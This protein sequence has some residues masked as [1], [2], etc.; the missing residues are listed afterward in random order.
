MMDLIFQ[1]IIKRP[2]S[3]GNGV[4][5]RFIVGRNWCPDAFIMESGGTEVVNLME[6]RTTCAATGGA[7][8]QRLN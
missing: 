3:A 8:G 1:Y 7:V 2:S 5:D 6:R 4:L